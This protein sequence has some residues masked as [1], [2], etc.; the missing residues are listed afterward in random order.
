MTQAT[1]S[2]IIVGHQ[3]LM[4][5]AK[6]CMSIRLVNARYSARP[7]GSRHERALSDSY[8]PG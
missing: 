2:V 6:L 8:G 7:S 1:D 3:P 5:Y 4:E